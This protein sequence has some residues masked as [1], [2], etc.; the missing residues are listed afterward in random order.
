MFDADA[1]SGQEPWR[2]PQSCSRTGLLYP[3][4]R[5]TGRVCGVYLWLILRRTVCSVRR[6][7]EVDEVAA[8]DVADAGRV[9][10]GGV[11][12]AV[13]GQQGGI[14]EDF[15]EGDGADVGGGCVVDGADDSTR[16]GVEATGGSRTD[17]CGC[18][19]LQANRL[20]AECAPKSG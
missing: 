16:F 19:V 5:G 18:Q 9:G 13:P 10:H 7:G 12:V 1:C 6:E 17:R 3:Q 4:A 2:R 11:I 20:N 15:G 14:A 8:G